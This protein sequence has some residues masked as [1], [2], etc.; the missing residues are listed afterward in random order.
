MWRN[1]YNHILQPNQPC[2]RPDDWWKLVSPPSSYHFSGV[3][4]AMAD[5]SVRFVRDSVDADIWLAAGTREGG[6]SLALP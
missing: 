4:V 6:E 5:G 2:W 1:W 3:N